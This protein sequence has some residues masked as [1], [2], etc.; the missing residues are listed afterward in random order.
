MKHHRTPAF[1]FFLLL[2]LLPLLISASANSH[3]VKSNGVVS[4]NIETKVEG[5]GHQIVERE[6]GPKRRRRQRK[7]GRKA[8][9]EGR[10]KKCKKGRSSC[11][12]KSKSKKQEGG[13]KRGKDLRGRK[14]EKGQVLKKS[15]KGQKTNRLRG[16][17][18]QSGV[19]VT[20]CITKLIFYS[21][22][23]EKKASAISRQVKRIKG[24]CLKRAK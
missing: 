9:E 22:L 4:S 18:R 24:D 13:R 12:K 11:Q 2:G 17:E 16:R 15:K 3:R 19:N 14:Q 20:A 21:R 23:N 8:K 10:S 5:N 7:E 1:H 6:A